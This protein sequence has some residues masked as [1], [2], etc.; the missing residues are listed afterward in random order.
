[1]KNIIMETIAH[2]YGGGS[3]KGI[4]QMGAINNVLSKGIYPAILTGVSVG[5]L[6]A[7]LLANKVGE[8]YNVHPSKR[9][10]WMEVSDYLKQFWMD[11]IT[12]PNDI[13][14]KK[15]VLKLIWELARGKFNG[16]SDTT[17]LRNLINRTIE[18]RNIL[19]SRL[20]I[21]SGCVN[22]DEGKIIYTNPSMAN[23]NQYI[24]ASSS[25]PFMMPVEQIG[26]LKFIDGGLIDSAPIAQAIKMGATKIIVFANHPEKVGHRAINHNNPIEYADRLM[27]IIVNNTLN[28]D[29]MEAQL[30]N[31]LLTDGV[32][33]ERTKNKKLIDIRVIR[34]KTNI[35]L[36]IDN[37]T[38]GEMI[39]IWQMGWDEAES[40]SL[41]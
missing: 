39:D 9:V 28:N 19:N 14:Y 17:P 24:L 41:M 21:S 18:P 31:E 23:L 8:H 10:N 5:N 30:I 7:N 34:P 22:L 20:K 11:N 13:A 12:C 4:W 1:M 3:I 38:K 37:F 2:V 32:R 26:Q 6:N 33:C 29:L 36:K 15:G 16:F 25:I 35:D 27:E 40:S